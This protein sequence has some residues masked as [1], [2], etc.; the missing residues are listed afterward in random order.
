MSKPDSDTSDVNNIPCPLCNRPMLPCFGTIVETAS[1]KLT[2]LYCPV[3]QYDEAP[4]GRERGFK[5]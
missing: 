4:I 1:M 5:L 2:R 3:C